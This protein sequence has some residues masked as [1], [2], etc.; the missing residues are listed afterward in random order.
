MPTSPQPAAQLLAADRTRITEIMT[1]GA[2]TVRASLSLEQLVDL[3][4]E[5]GISRAPVVDD[6]GR[7][8][9]M[10]S[11]TDLVIAQH[12]RGDTEV[13]QAGAGGWG[14]HVHELGSTVRDVM[15]PVVFSLPETT[16]IGEAARR[17]LADN[18]HAVP[19]VSA[20]DQL[21]GLLSATDIMAWVAGVQF[22]PAP[23]AGAR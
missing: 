17:M 20:Q 16:S 21:V 19:V 11:K 8:I 3:F 12:E 13:S 15:T 6:D 9:G 2:I 4:L 7:P 14:R 23:A 10:V 5:Q 22:P 18:V 1:R